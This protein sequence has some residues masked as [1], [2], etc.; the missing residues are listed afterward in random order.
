MYVLD[1]Q[2]VAADELPDDDTL[3]SKHVAVDTC[4]EVSLVIC[5]IAF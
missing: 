1:L 2:T 5:F 3:V 4:Y